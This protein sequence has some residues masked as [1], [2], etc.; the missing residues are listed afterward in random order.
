MNGSL[1]PFGWVTNPSQV[2][3]PH[4]PTLEGGKTN[5]SQLWQKNIVCTVGIYIVEE[6]RLREQVLQLQEKLTN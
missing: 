5:W 4:L 2:S 3:P 6:E 1:T